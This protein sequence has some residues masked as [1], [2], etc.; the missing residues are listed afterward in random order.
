MQFSP[1]VK[2]NTQIVNLIH[3]N[4]AH[5]NSH[6][7]DTE[8]NIKILFRL[9]LVVPKPLFRLGFKPDCYNVGYGN[10]KFK[11]YQYNTIKFSH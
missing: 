6:I 8:N 2:L 9:G 3:K 11:I 10:K 4:L 7:N 1:F 5:A